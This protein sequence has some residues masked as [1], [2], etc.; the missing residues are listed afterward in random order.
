MCG[1]YRGAVASSRTT[2]SE[3]R[4][5]IASRRTVI[6]YATYTRANT[7]GLVVQLADGDTYADCI[8]SSSPEA[9]RGTEDYNS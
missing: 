7:D 4:G 8:D 2:C 3:D 5:A 6:Q 9:N 1:E